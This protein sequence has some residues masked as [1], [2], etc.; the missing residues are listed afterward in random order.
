MMKLHFL[1]SS[2][3]AGFKGESVTTDVKMQNLIN[4]H[5]G[6]SRTVMDELLKRVQLIAF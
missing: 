6:Y 5:T 1:K 2:L 4:K 3:E